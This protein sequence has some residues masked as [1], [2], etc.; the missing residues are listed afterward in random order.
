MWL[1]AVVGFVIFYYLFAFI[2]LWLLLVQFHWSRTTCAK[3][4]CK[5]ECFLEQICPLFVLYRFFSCS[6]FVICFFS[7]RKLSD[8]FLYDGVFFRFNW[9]YASIYTHWFRLL[10]QIRQWADWNTR[11]LCVHVFLLLSFLNVCFE[12][13]S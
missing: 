10:N 3:A 6:K 13:S 8:V 4:E 1:V 12:A 9:A 11:F 5:T 7:G 2:H